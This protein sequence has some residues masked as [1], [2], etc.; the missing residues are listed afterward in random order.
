MDVNARPVRTTPLFIVPPGFVY[1]LGTQSMPTPSAGYPPPHLT[2][3]LKPPHD[4]RG[5]GTQGNSSRLQSGI[6][7]HNHP[8]V[9]STSHFLLPQE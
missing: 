5:H 6:S 2:R 3:H 7:P 8:G 1:Y 4:S 9:L